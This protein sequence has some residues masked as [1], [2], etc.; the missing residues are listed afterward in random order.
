[1]R[2]ILA[3]LLSA[4]SAFAGW[5]ACNTAGKSVPVRVDSGDLVTLPIPSAKSKPAYVAFL[6]EPLA[7]NLI[8]RTIICTFRIDNTGTPVYAIGYSGGCPSPANLR[9]YFTTISGSYNLNNGEHHPHEYW[10]SDASFSSFVDADGGLIITFV[11]PLHAD[12]WSDALGGSG[13]TYPAAFASALSRCVQI[14][15]S[16]GGGCFFDTGVGMTSGTATMH[17]LNYTAQ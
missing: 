15:F 17:V 9:L 2:T 8:G 7:V 3:L 11:D 6:T 16:F 10:W 13:A 12:Q 14:G 1:M 4:Q 5:S